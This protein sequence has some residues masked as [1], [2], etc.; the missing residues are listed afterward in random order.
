VV[1]SEANGTLKVSW[2]PPTAKKNQAPDLMRKVAT[3]Q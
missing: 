1:V 3:L 2:G